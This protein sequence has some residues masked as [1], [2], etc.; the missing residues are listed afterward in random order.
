M[1]KTKKALIHHLH[2]DVYCHLGV[3]KIAGIGVFALRQIP[4]GIDPL[5]TWLPTKEMSI[6]VD[7]LNKLPTPVRK[8]IHMFCYVDNKK[9][10]VDIPV[11][12]MNAMN[13]AVYLNHSK[14]PSLKFTKVGELVSLKRINAGEEL[15]IDYDKSFG[16]KHVFK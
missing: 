8:Q 13:M 14:K 2:E 10:K 1:I 15:T 4:K 9:G 3:S 7:E 5:R 12:G 6:S 11:Y 16:E